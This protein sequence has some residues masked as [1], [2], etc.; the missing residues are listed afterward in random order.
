VL[1]ADAVEVRDLPVDI[2]Q[3]LDPG[4]FFTEEDLRASGERLDVRPVLGETSQ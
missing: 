1:L 4:R 2:V 3:N